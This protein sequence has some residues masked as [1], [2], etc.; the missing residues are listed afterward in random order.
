MK[1]GYG[2]RE[3]LA[4]RD[5]IISTLNDGYTLAHVHRELLSSGKITIKYS[6]FHKI[7]T[8]MN[9]RPRII[10]KIKVG[11]QAVEQPSASLGLE[12]QQKREESQLQVQQG[13]GFNIIKKPEDEVF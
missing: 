10:K 13:D 1:R 11:I 3:I 12:M 4:C 7:L 9:I 8:R 5:E 6:H 2:I